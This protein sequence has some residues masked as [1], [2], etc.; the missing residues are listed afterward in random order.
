MLIAGPRTKARVRS[1]RRGTVLPA[2]V[3]AILAVLA[4][5]VLAA[6]GSTGAA[7]V[8]ALLVYAAAT[9]LAHAAGLR[10]RPPLRVDWP[11]EGTASRL[12]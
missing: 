7:L 10:R 8:T 9:P 11:A 3:V 1:P 6:N 4:V 12:S 5:A 2:L